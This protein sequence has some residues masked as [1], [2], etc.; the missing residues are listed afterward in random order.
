MVKI[1]GFYAGRNDESDSFADRFRQMRK[2]QAIS[3]KLQDQGLIQ[4]YSLEA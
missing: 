2:L 3:R 4:Y 1:P